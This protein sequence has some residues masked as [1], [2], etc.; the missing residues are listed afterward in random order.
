M[1]NGSEVLL[2]LLLK[3]KTLKNKNKLNIV[4]NVFLR[5]SLHVFLCGFPNNRLEIA[6]GHYFRSTIKVCED[7]CL[8]KYMF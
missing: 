5:M 8:L 1:A 3:L 7:V 4:L 6:F 2:G